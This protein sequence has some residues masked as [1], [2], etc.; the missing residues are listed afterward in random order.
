MAITDYFLQTNSRRILLAEIT[1]SNAN[2]TVY[3]LADQPYVTEPSDTPA[4]CPYSAVIA[5]L[6]E[7]SRKLPDHFSGSASTSFGTLSLASRNGVYT[8]TVSGYE[9]M[10]LPRGAIVTLKLAAPR[11]LFPHSSALT[12]AVGKVG[13][14]GGKSDG[15]LTAEITDGSDAIKRAVIP[16]TTKPLAFGKVRN[17]APFLTT[18]ASLIYTLHDGPIQAVD[19][20][21]DDGVLIPGANYTVNLTN[22]TVTLA[23][24]PAGQV[25]VD[26]QGQKTG[27]VTYL[28]NT[29]QIVGELLSRAGFGALTQTY[30]SLPTGTIGLY[31]TQTTDLEELLTSLLRGCGGYWFMTSTGDFKAALFPIPGTPG[32][33][34]TDD[35]LLDEVDYAADD[36]LH[37]AIR[38]NYQRNWTQYQSRTGASTTQAD[39]SPRQAY[40]GSVVDGAPLAEYIYQTSPIL[41]TYFD[42]N[43]DAATAATRYLNIFRQPRWLLENVNVPFL[44]TRELGDAVSIQFD[45]LSFDGVVM[46]ITNVFTGDYP[47]QVLE[48]MA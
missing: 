10:Q 46:G 36:R 22:A 45:G 42:A 23:N 14:I 13:R 19:A 4:N 35:S 44:Y 7:L 39:F 47:T 27:G 2:A 30:S 31:L 43:G 24:T 12:L 28:S 1:R 21:Y 3:R 29:Q 38:Y 8:G 26:F 5:S 48:V 40:E 6:P 37:S 34:Y 33:T 17:A 9:D 25:T 16:V 11:S 32:D 18:P 20:V 41:E 15:T